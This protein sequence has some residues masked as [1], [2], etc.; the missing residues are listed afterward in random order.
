MRSVPL[1]LCQRPTPLP[2]PLPS[3]FPHVPSHLPPAS[4]TRLCLRS[5]LHRISST[6]ASTHFRAGAGALSSSGDAPPCLPSSP[7]LVSPT[8]TDSSIQTL[9]SEYRCGDQALRMRNRRQQAC[10]WQ[11]R[12]VLSSLLLS[13]CAAPR[14]AL[15]RSAPHCSAPRAALI[16]SALLSSRAVVLESLRGQDVDGKLGGSWSEGWTQAQGDQF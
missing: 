15:H 4:R 3:T 7:S 1:Q 6:L 11:V 14:A 2:S 10:V 13:S 12:S 16:S 5:C 8:L 9:A